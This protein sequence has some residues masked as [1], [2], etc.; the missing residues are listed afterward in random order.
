MITTPEEAE[1][2]LNTKVYDVA[3]LVVCRDEHD[4]LWDDY[5]ALIE[6]ITST[7]K[8]TTW[9]GVG[10]PGA[11]KGNALGTA[12]VL[13]VSQTRDVHEE[14]ADLLKNIRE[15]AKKNPNAGTPRRNR[16]ARRSS[17]ENGDRPRRLSRHAARHCASGKSRTRSSRR[18]RKRAEAREAA[19][20]A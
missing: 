6:I 13:V 7:I 18:C 8:P 19:A 12:K 9:D 15:I 2:H 10:G 16:P 11:I 4:A 20:E 5:D 3:D 1:N 14:I 17:A